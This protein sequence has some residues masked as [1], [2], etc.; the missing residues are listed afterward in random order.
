MHTL[1][2]IVGLFVAACL[3]ATAHAQSATGAYDAMPMADYLGLLEQIAPAA[4]GG[5]ETYLRAHRQRCG[6]QLTTAEL[7]RAMSESSGDTVLMGMIRAT[8]VRDEPALST[9]AQSLPCGVRK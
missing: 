9:L 3:A 8:Q 7:R 1:A 4:R 2:H 5:A 6:R